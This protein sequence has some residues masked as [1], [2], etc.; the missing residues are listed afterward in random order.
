[1]AFGALL[2]G[3]GVDDEEIVFVGGGLGVAEFGGGD[4]LV[5][6][7]G[8]LWGKFLGVGA[9]RMEENCERHREGERAEF[10]CGEHGRTLREKAV[11]LNAVRV[12]SG[13]CEGNFGSI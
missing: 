12:N 4:V 6:G 11:R 3:L 8:D 9:R 10:F 1:M 7:G 2:G 5:E 13:C